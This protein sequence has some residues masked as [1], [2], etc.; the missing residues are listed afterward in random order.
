MKLVN[1]SLNLFQPPTLTG[2]YVVFGL[3]AKLA[4]RLALVED[5]LFSSFIACFETDVL[6]FVALVRIIIVHLTSE[7]CWGWRAILG[8]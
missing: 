4:T 1:D 7:N 2:R 6:T 8:N 3:V 5:N